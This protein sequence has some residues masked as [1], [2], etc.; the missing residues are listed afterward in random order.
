MVDTPRTISLT[1]G[2]RTRVDIP[3]A[4]AARVS[5]KVV[6]LP[7]PTD[8]QDQPDQ[9]EQVTNNQTNPQPMDGVGLRLVSESRSYY[10]RSGAS[11]RFSFGRLRPGEWRIEVDEDTPR[12]ALSKTRENQIST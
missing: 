9:E 3:V 8:N 10:T 5:G 12:A 7:E 11:G 4:E 2:E 1:A 6:R